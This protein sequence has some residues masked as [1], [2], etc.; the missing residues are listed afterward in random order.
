MAVPDAGCV[1]ER[2]GSHG[3]PEDGC[4]EERLGFSWQS[5]TLV[6]GGRG[7]GSYGSPRC[8]LLVGKSLIL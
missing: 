5:Q 1:R 8:W 7:G 4:E 6:V 2:P 3:S